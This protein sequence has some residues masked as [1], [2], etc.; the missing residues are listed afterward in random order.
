[1]AKLSNDTIKYTKP[2]I[3][4]LGSQTSPDSTLWYTNWIAYQD[5][6]GAVEVA[7]AAALAYLVAEVIPP[8]V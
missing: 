1:M 3:E 8:T 7:V 2:T 6:V 5:Y 4:Q